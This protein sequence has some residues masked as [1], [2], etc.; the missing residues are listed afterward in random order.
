MANFDTITKIL[1]GDAADG[2][3][4]TTAGSFAEEVNTYLE[5]IDDAKLLSITTAFQPTRTNGEYKLAVV[6]I[7]KV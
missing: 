2:E 5:T 3:I 4:S 7:T 1:V 6:V